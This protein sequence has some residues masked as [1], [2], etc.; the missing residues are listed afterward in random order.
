MTTNDSE[1]SYALGVPRYRQ[2]GWRSVVPLPPKAKYPPPAG[3]TGF[4]GA[5][6][7]EEDYRRWIASYPADAN[8]GLRLNYG[9]VATDTDAHSGKTGGQTLKEAERRWTEPPP[10]YRSS[11][12][13]DDPI[14][15][16]R[17]FKVPLG[18]LFRGEIKFADDLR[19]VD[20]IQPHH[21]VV[22]AWPSTHKS[23]GRY[24]WYAP[25]GSLMP[26]G[27]G[28]LCGRLAGAADA[29]GRRAIPRRGARVGVRQLDSQPVRPAGAAINEELYRKL[30]VLPDDGEPDMVIA[31][32]LERALRELTDGEKSRYETARDHVLGLMRLHHIGRVGVPRALQQLYAAYVLEVGDTRPTGVAE[33]EFLR[34]TQ[35]AAM[36]IAAS[37]PGQQPDVDQPGE[38]LPAVLLV[39]AGRAAAIAPCV[40][41]QSGQRRKRPR[42]GKQP[43]LCPIHHIELIKGSW[44]EILLRL[45]EFIRIA[46]QT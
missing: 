10:T 20:I 17:L 29:M 35:G 41:C 15:G 8:T 19:H 39:S 18:V 34:F 38:S 40:A 23:G 6:P 3:F 14:S 42:E 11:A 21:R 16:I 7:T 33:A 28:A 22:A 9:V 25:D 36:L 31:P 32:R 1:A 44:W 45:W 12:R 2:A 30:I 43:A 37:L 13:P 4:D 24:R 5:W 26:R 46:R 27:P